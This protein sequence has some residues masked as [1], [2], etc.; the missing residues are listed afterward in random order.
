[1][2]KRWI[3]FIIVILLVF[4]YPGR[5]YPQLQNKGTIIEN[6]AI[7]LYLRGFSYYYSGDYRE[8]ASL[9]E[10]A[11]KLFP[12]NEEI[13]RA[14]G[15][16]YFQLGVEAYREDDLSQAKGYFFEVIEYL[17]DDFRGYQNLSLILVKLKDYKEASRIAQQGLKLKEDSREL[18]LLLAEC[19]R[20]ERD[21]RKLLEVFE[22]LHK[23]YPEDL[24]I[25]LDLARLYRIN[26]KTSEAMKLYRKLKED[27]PKERRIYERIAEIHASGFRYKEAREEYEALLE[28]Y[29]DDPEI[30]EKIAELF[31]LEGRYSE[32][33]GV[34]EEL[35]KSSPKQL[36]N[37]IKIAEIYEEEKDIS[38]AINTYKRAKKIFPK[39]ILIYR[40][41]GRLYE[42]QGANFEAEKAYKKMIELDP[43]ES[44]PWVRLGILY[45]EREDFNS[46]IMSFQK[47]AELG[48]TD[49]IPYYKLGTHCKEREEATGYIKLAVEKALKRIDEIRGSLFGR[50][51]ALGGQ[52]NLSELVQLER[53]AGE[54]D[55]PEEML[56]KALEELLKLRG[57][58]VEELE[59]DLKTFL[60]E[61]P[62]NEQ[63]LEEIGTLYEKQKR[64]DEAV[65]IWKRL[66]KSNIKSVRAHL[67]L[68]RAYEGL[69]RYKEA[70]LAY[71]RVIELDITCREAYLGLIRLYGERGKLNLL[72]EEWEKKAKIR[73]DPLLLEY[74]SKLKEEL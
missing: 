37:Y 73:S 44:Y 69:R 54:L 58:N 2:D 21:E 59:L 3:K 28:F 60:E 36:S 51:Q 18:L 70:I 74:L 6:K 63:L 38:S 1:M 8:A 61:Y 53:K 32:A 57:E 62:E 20:E 71:K 52:I 24:E 11:L 26:R 33:R 65:I 15:A 27:Y 22:K 5:S 35:I 50:M 29:P 39:H 16:C 49:P 72:K 68:A 66:L 56:K 4:L 31:R 17:P 13:K 30:R 9:F 55:E 46:A 23:Y 40:E 45:E 64:L 67:G 48:S 34:Y 43:F 7:D 12:E 41:L 14:L 47:A 25:A 10:E 42:L 19:Y